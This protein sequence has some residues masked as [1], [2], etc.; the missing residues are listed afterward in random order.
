MQMTFPLESLEVNDDDSDNQ[1]GQRWYKTG[2]K[3]HVDKHGLLTVV[4]RYARFA[5]I[6][7][8]LNYLSAIETALSE[9]L[10]AEVEV[11]TACKPYFT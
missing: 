4:D 9:V 5:K 6:G 3:R 11:L 2:D 10:P 8:E 7:G 1:N